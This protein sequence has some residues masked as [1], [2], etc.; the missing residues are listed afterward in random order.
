MNNFTTFEQAMAYLDCANHYFDS[1]LMLNIYT[2]V[3]REIIRSEY[4]W[5][6]NKITELDYSKITDDEFNAISDA[7]YAFRSHYRELVKD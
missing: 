2:R 3:M 6:C 1:V 7:Y 4:I 5:T